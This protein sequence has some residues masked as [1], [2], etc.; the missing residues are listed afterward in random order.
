MQGSIASLTTTAPVFTHQDFHR[1]DLHSAPLGAGLCSFVVEQHTEPRRLD[2]GSVLAQ[3]FTSCGL[4]GT[5]HYLP[6]C[7]F[8]YGFYL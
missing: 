1:L 3:P 7:C 8:L 4:F 5:S 6:D 2:L